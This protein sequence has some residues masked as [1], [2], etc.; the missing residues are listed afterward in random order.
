[1]ASHFASVTP[2]RGCA[3]IFTLIRIRDLR[4]DIRNPDPD[5]N[6]SPKKSLRNPSVETAKLRAEI[7]PSWLPDRE[8]VNS[9]ATI[10][11]I[12]N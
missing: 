5:P 1:M 3:P 12:L 9:L 4:R 7:C 11:E 10:K 6:R 8:A 2:N